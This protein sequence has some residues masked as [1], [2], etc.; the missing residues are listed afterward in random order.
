MYLKKIP[1]KRYEGAAF[2]NKVNIL[3]KDGY[4]WKSPFLVDKLY[5]FRYDRYMKQWIIGLNY[6]HG[7]NTN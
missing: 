7:A 4:P 2:F 3:L 1:C 6:R 5:L